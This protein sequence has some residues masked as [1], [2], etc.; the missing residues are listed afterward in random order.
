MRTDD[1]D[2]IF[3]NP[4]ISDINGYDSKNLD[5]T[6]YV[7]DFPSIHV[8]PDL[9]FRDVRNNTLTFD[10]SRISTPIDEISTDMCKDKSCV[11]NVTNIHGNHTK[12]NSING[13]RIDVFEPKSFD[14]LGTHQIKYNVKLSNINRLIQ[15]TDGQTE[16]LVVDYCSKFG[17][18]HPFVNWDSV[19]KTSFEKIHSIALHYL[20]SQCDGEDSDLYELRRA[21]IN[22]YYHAFFG[23]TFDFKRY[24]NELAYSNATQVGTVSYF[25]DLMINFSYINIT[26]TQLGGSDV[27]SKK[28]HSSVSAVLDP[29]WDSITSE[30][31]PSMLSKTNSTALFKREGYGRLWVKFDNLT[32]IVDQETLVNATLFGTTLSKDFG[33]YDAK[34]LSNYEYLFPHSATDL[35]VNITGIH[36]DHTQNKD[37]EIS[38]KLSPYMD[39]SA[40]SS[41]IQSFDDATPNK[42]V[43]I[44]RYFQEHASI[45]GIEKGNVAMQ[46]ADFHDIAN[47]AT[48]MGT[49]VVSMNKSIVYIPQRHWEMIGISND[50]DFFQY[51]EYVSSNVPGLYVLHI[52]A[53]EKTKKYPAKQYAFNEHVSEFINVDQ[54][55]TLETLRFGDV[56]N[57]LNSNEF[58][59]ISSIHVNKT[60]IDRHCYNGCFFVVP[61]GDTV[62]IDAYNMWGG[63]VSTISIMAPPMNIDQE[64]SMLEKTLDSYLPHILISVVFFFSYTIIKRARKRT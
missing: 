62:Q 47:S 12:I 61:H 58:G 10:V 28:P 55:N 30:I 64:F 1:I 21:K 50:D 29:S 36:S 22:V 60:M 40:D 54:D 41:Q 8:K 31:F 63:M 6:Y 18:V 49:Q 19:G 57:I 23:Q 24:I 53:N 52:D 44:P 3:E 5:S 37:L 2:I 48:Y 20:G 15:D 4:P 45:A 26:A 35:L 38:V 27:L 33:G 13:D 43:Y 51:P 32:D 11:L 17:Q 39:S 42:T 34:Y 56:I 59:N 7:G 16:I 46:I 14:D 9:L 25:E